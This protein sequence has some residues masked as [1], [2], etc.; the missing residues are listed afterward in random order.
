MIF[1]LVGGGYKI[2]LEPLVR[3]YKCH[4]SKIYFAIGQKL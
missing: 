2:I 1:F 3:F 4:Y